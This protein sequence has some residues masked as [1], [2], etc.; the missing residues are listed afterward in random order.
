MEAIVPAP[1]D[2]LLVSPRPDGKSWVLQ[3][4]FELRVSGETFRVPRGF[5]TDFATVPRA[6]WWLLP[7][8]GTYGSAAVLH[9]W[10]YWDRAHEGCRAEADSLFRDS[11]RELGVNPII[12]EL[13]YCAVRIFG[14]EAWERNKARR[15]VS[16]AIEDPA[17]KYQAGLHK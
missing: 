11:M 3:A 7:Q 2:N 14:G 10:L 15:A 13:M 16:Q 5:V 6:F 12:R 9:D 17:W 4:D 1:A 8:W